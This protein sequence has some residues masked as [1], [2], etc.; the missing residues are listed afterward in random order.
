MAL[1]AGDI[2]FDIK[3]DDTQLR[4]ALDQA[5]GAFSGA[6]MA[7][8]TAMT[9]A[10]VAITG[11]ATQAVMDF[12]ETG[13][14][15]NDMALRTGL[16][17][18]KLQE[19]GYAAGLSGASMDDVEKA[20]KRMSMVVFQAGEESKAAGVKQQEAWA[21]GSTEVVK[22][23]GTYTDA[24][25]MIGLS[26]QELSTLTPDQQFL[27]VGFALAG[28]EDATMR[29][30]LAQQLFGRTGTALLP[31]LAEGRGGFQAMADEA[32]RL[33]IVM[34]A[35]SVAAADKM[36]DSVDKLKAAFRGFAFDV[37]E[38]L[39]PALLRIV[40]GAQNIMDTFAAWRAA[41]PALFD[42]IAS[43]VIVIGGV[44][45]VL[46]PLLIALPSLV[47]AFTAVKTAVVAVGAVFAALSAAIGAPVAVVGLVIANL[48]VWG[49]AI[50]ENW[51]AIK[52]ALAAVWR[53][54]VETFKLIFAPLFLAWEMMEGMWLDA[55][56]QTRFGGGPQYAMA[57]P[58]GGGGPQF[59]SAGPRGGGGGNG[60]GGSGINMSFNIYGAGDPT[61]VSRQIAEQLRIELGARGL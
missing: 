60:G 33:G 1:N 7:M 27:E 56:R 53:G 46:G 38:V 42:S 59:A 39:L 32:R 45:T 61:A 26:Y 4:Q 36:G 29:A 47:G 43:L 34:D 22:A 31:M 40:N 10:G 18:E 37:A 35:S 41:N 58:G 9:A 8:G 28:V 52:E 14:A 2:V 30:A 50:V 19:L 21:K 23:T 16:S 44:M 12:V 20:A 13:S 17:A 15:V 48:I 49:W 6:S 25:G 3:A 55:E 24:L 51:A 57:G 54:I 11:F 5:K